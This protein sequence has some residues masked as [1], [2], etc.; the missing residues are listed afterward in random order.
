M[1][2]EEERPQQADT[3]AAADYFVIT[4]T[5]ARY[6]VSTVMARH[7]ERALDAWPRRPW[8]T[9]VDVTGA[10]VRVRTG[11]VLGIAQSSAE[12]RGAWRALVRALRDEER[13]DG[14]WDDD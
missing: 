8:V 5:T 4:T 14:D 10:R 7:V 11:T 9:F 13:A 2:P 12:Q 1:T 6:P 3:A